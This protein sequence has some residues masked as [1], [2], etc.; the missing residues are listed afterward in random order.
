MKT[1]LLLSVSLLIFCCKG[2]ENVNSIAH[3]QTKTP[4][5]TVK[6]EQTQ[7]QISQVVRMMFQDSKGHLWFGTE[8]GAFKHSNDS[9]LH[10]D[11]I[12]SA[13]GREV[14]IKDIK[15][16]KDGTIWI[17]HTAGISSVDGEKVLNY[18][19][20]DGLA[21]N[22]VWC[23]ETDK[24][25]NVWIGTIEGVSIY[26]GKKFTKFELPEGEIDRT[27]GVSSK[28][29]VHNITEDSK[30]LIWFCTNAGLFSYANNQITNVSE[31]VG[32]QTNFVNEVYEDKNGTVWV[33]TKQGLYKIAESKAMN[34]TEGKLETGKGIGSITEDKTGKLWFVSNQH[35]LFT[36]DGNEIEEVQKPEH[37]KG[38]VVFQIY[39]DQKQ[40]LWFVGYG[41]AFRMENDLFLNITKS[42]P[43]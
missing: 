35:Y 27:R 13:T 24:E 3:E 4:I 10:L 14:T 2:Q 23:I 8:D 39:K 7:A 17:G 32:I 16:D 11:K 5:P 30:G 37:N 42:G 1:L 29:M 41:G 28:K 31:S 12:R 33:S 19:E 9:L 36:Y 25:G 38:P 20:S 22:D 6:K 18:Y 40:R 21:S 15:E 43:W 26:D 34:I